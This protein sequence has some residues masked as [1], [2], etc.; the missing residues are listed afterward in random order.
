MRAHKKNGHQARFFVPV[1]GG[2][3]AYLNARLYPL[4]SGLAHDHIGQ[5]RALGLGVAQVNLIVHL[6]LEE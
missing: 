2:G 6:S 1:P 4:L 3:T 5:V